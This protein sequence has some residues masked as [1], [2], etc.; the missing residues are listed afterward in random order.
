MIQFFQAI[1]AC[2]VGLIACTLVIC[3]MPT[4]LSMVCTPHQSHLCT[5]MDG[6]WEMTCHPLKHAGIFK[7]L[8]VVYC[9][10]PP[11]TLSK[12]GFRIISVLL[13]LA[14][15]SSV[16]LSATGLYF[17]LPAAVRRAGSILYLSR[18]M[19]TTPLAL[20]VLKLQL[21]FTPLIFTSSV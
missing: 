8:N 19:R 20:S 6:R 4:H 15:P 2:V 11:I 21:S 12:S 5:A 14:L 16:V 1:P 7:Y 13:F 9:L 3:N 10:R 17:P 18:K